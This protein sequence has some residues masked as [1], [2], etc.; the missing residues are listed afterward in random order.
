MAQMSR[1]P[2]PAITAR[3]GRVARAFSLVEVMASSAILAL[4]MAAVVS[5]FANLTFAYSHQR[6]QVQA[7]HVGEGVLED[8]LLRYANDNDLK[9]G[10]HIGPGFN[11][12]G[13]PGGTFYT[14]SW[15]VTAGVPI[16]NAREVVVTVSW[17][18]Q[19]ISKA[20]SLRTVRT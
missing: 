5:L 1:P 20:F 12:D 4:G 3:R 7:L 15:S 2:R 18:E 10:P 9:P 19:G 8:L 13:T 16:P 17:S 14:T 11:V 6:M